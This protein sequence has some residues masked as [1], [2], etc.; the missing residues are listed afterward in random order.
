MNEKEPLT[1]EQLHEIGVRRKGDEDVRALLWEIKR[2]RD[3]LEVKRQEGIRDYRIIAKYYHIARSLPDQA[4]AMGM[5]Y[6]SLKRELEG[7]PVR[8]HQDGILPTLLGRDLDVQPGDDDLP[9]QG[10]A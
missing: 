2:L 6:A 1:V 3:E 7:H 5:V 10:G 8:E 9:E 4:G